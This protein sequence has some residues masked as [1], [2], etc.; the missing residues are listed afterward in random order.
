LAGVINLSKLAKI[1]DQ[2]LPWHNRNEDELFYI[3][4]SEL[5]NG[6]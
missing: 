6:N 1:K 5:F 4:E 2:D 3:V